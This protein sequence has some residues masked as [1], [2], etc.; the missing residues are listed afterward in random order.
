MTV[1]RLQLL[2]DRGERPKRLPQRAVGWIA[3]RGQPSREPR[4]L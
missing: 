1:P 2:K 3:A 4:R